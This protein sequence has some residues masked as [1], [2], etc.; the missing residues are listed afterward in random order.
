MAD[1]STEP[2]GFA[3]VF[4][5]LLGLLAAAGLVAAIK[6]RPKGR[7]VAEPDD[8]PNGHPS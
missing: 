6:G 5:P 1:R 2:S 8:T 4:G 3:R 7:V